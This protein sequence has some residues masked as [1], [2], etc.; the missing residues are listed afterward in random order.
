MAGGSEGASSIGVETE[1][2][3]S[4]KAALKSSEKTAADAGQDFRGT[5]GGFGKC[6]N[7]AHDERYGHGSLEALAA[8]IAKNH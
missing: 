5:G 3:A 2:D 1:R 6:A 8:Y 4:G 7:D